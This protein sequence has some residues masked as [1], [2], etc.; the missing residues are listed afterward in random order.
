MSPALVLG[1]PQS[2]ACWCQTPWEGPLDS[3]PRVWVR[4]QEAAGPDLLVVRLA[5]G[6]AE[7]RA[8]VSRSVGGSILAHGAFKCHQGLGGPC[9]FSNLDDQ[10]CP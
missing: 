6:L 7:V 10:R 3:Q 2:P 8:L 4:P 5:E 9:P 1:G